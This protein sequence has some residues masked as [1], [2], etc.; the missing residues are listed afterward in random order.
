MLKY[1]LWAASEKAL[2]L[3]PGGTLVYKGLGRIANG[4]G[5]SARRLG[6]CATSYRLVQMAKRMTPAGGVVLDVGTGWHHHDAFLIY[7]CGNYKTYLFDIEDK[8]TLEYIQVY[9]RHLL[10]KLDEVVAALEVDREQT[11]QKLQRLLALSSREDIYRA[12]NFTLCITRQTDRPFL[13]EG[14]VDF[15][16]S[17]C[18]LSHIP[19]AL[20][21]PELVALR[22]MLK[23]SGIMY[24]LIGH[25]DQWSF[26]DASSNAFNYYRFSDRFYRLLFETKFE[27]QNRMV[28][29]EWLPVFA[30]AGLKVMDYSSHVSDETREHIRALRH[31]DKRFA[32]YSLEELAIR[33][34]YFLLGPVQ[35]AECSNLRESS[36]S[37][38]S[39]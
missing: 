9:L 18:V 28:K 31:V 3:M 30:D 13:P 29:S 36:S 7:L 16:T 24:M 37:H 2:S 4:N 12:C 33:H 26:H 15:M 5:R 22:R 14:S 35:S 39:A 6:S 32:R 17:N 20:L 27:Y 25:D 10:L 38:N 34:S 8:A 19:P 1:Y 11:Q 23:P 21:R